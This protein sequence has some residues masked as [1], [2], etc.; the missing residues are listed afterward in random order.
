MS[1]YGKTSLDIHDKK[2][3]SMLSYQ[4]SFKKPY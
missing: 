4:N 2:K 1:L 3:K